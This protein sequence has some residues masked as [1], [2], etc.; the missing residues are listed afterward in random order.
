MKSNFQRLL[1]RLVLPLVTLS[2]MPNVWQKALWSSTAY[3][4]GIPHVLVN[5][6]F[7]VRDG[8]HTGQRPGQVLHGHGTTQVA[9]VLNR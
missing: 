7:V 4:S 9:A 8:K 2:S 5:G 1:M 3:A 6:L